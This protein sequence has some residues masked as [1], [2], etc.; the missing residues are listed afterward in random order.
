M[1]LRPIKNIKNVL[2]DGDT[3][4]QTSTL[5]LM[6]I[7]EGSSSEPVKRI[8]MFGG[9]RLEPKDVTAVPPLASIPVCR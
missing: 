8:L 1:G 3:R 9:G 7:H 5:S 4:L 6:N 2:F